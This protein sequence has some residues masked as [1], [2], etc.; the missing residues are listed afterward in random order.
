MAAFLNPCDRLLNFVRKG[1]FGGG[2]PRGLHLHATTTHLVAGKLKKA[3]GLLHVAWSAS[4]TWQA[5]DR[6]DT[7][8]TT[9]V[10][11]M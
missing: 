3:H 7:S 10:S 4:A 2:A 9:F 1:T 6:E 11:R 5:L 8:A